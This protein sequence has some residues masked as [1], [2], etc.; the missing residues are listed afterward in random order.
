V[1]DGFAAD[2]IAVYL[3]V[4]CLNAVQSVNTKAIDLN[5]YPS[6]TS[7]AFTVYFASATQQEVTITIADIT[8]RKAFEL[9]TETNLSIPVGNL[10]PGIY[11][12]TA[13]TKTGVK[14]HGKVTVTGH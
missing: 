14:Q 9:T 13:A 8:G 11:L 6:P 7:G 10:E 4:G 3:D 12:V 1:S 5:V 2:T